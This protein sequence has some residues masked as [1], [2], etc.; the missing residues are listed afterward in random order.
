MHTVNQGYND[1][2]PIPEVMGEA[3]LAVNHLGAL[4]GAPLARSHVV[5]LGR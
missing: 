1:P 3:K 5:Q 2:M 4:A